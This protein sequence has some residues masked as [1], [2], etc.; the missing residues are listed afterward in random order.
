MKIRRINLFGGP[1][2]GKSTMAAKIFAALKLHGVSVEHVQEYVKAWT[3]YNRRPNKWDQTYFF[4]KQ[5][6]AEYRYLAHCETGVVVTDSPLLQGVYYSQ[7]DSIK[8]N[9]LN[10]ALEYEQEFPSF[11]I[12]VYRGNKTFHQEGRWQ[13]LDE[14]KSIDTG[15]LK[16]L[17]DNNIDYSR[18]DFESFS[19]LN[20]EDLYLAMYPYLFRDITK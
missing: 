4:G 15:T 6:Q 18:L 13:N 16:L 8:S 10:L 3:Y 12:F 1:G 2:S 17:K 20:D 5:Q 7:S 9:L 11:N 19:K 14:A